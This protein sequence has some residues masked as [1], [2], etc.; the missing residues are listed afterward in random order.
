MAD[1]ILPALIIFF[2]VFTQSVAGFGV[3]LIA[4]A[5]LPGLLNINVTSP[6]V[7]LIALTLEVIL[8]LYYRHGLNFQ[9]IWKVTLMSLIG[10]PIGIQMLTKVNESLVLASL[11]VIL[12][13]YAGYSYFNF[14]LPELKHPGW[15]YFTGLIAG[16]LGGAYNT[17]GPPVILYGH[18]R[19]WPPLEFKSNLQAFFLVSSAFVA[20]AHFVHQNYTTEV[21]Q[22]YLWSLPAMAAGIL[23]GTRLDRYLEAQTFRKIVLVLIFIMGI[24]LILAS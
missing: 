18:C 12:S 4:M 3:A 14:K 24:R 19:R 21:L 17:S 23:L 5:L 20:I 1:H 6:L 16:L 2:A 13:S 9:A 10:I 15:A 8:F 7:A 11:G 22:H